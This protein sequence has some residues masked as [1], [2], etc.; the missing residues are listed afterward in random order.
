MSLG[1]NMSS[2]SK[3]GGDAST[4]ALDLKELKSMLTE[5]IVNMKFG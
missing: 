1:S 2:V 3:K 5:K 4:T